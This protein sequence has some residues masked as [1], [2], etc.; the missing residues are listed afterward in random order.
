MYF[1][2]STRGR[3][4]L[5]CILSVAVV[6]GCGTDSA[7]EQPS[8]VDQVDP[9]FAT[10]EALVA[11]ISSLTEREEPDF[12]AYYELFHPETP[13]QES[14]QRFAD[15]YIL[16]R[17]ELYLEIRRQFGEDT[18]DEASSVSAVYWRTKNLQLIEN[19]EQR[20]KAVFESDVRKDKDI[21]LIGIGGRWWVSGYT[22]EY[23]PTFHA[24]TTGEIARM[25]AGLKP[26]IDEVIRAVR[27]NEFSTPV[28]ATEA[29]T[30]AIRRHAEEG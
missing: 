12:R 5:C 10:A 22:W 16:P 24:E 11:R 6:A 30:E 23:H 17:A 8:E 15:E 21:Y 4:V 20:A 3:A 7:S 27:A 25:S 18:D 1:D 26:Y 13:A 2:A 19:G 9:R 28:E 29:F 14:W